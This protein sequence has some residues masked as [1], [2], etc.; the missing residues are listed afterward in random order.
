M[1]DHV[2]MILVTFWFWVALTFGYWRQ[3]ERRWET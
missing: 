1:L 3:W 2:G